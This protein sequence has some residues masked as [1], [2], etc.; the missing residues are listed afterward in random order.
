MQRAHRIRLNPTP[1][2]DRYF[3]QATGTARFTYN[4]LLGRWQA[5]KADKP[6]E[7]HGVMDLKKE[8]N[9][10]RGEQFP[11]SYDVTK[12]VIEGAARNLAT[13]FKNYF[14]SKSGKRQGPSVGFPNFKRKRDTHQSFVLNNDKF[15]VDD[16]ALN[17]PKLG[18]VD[19]TES[20]RFEGKIMGAVV[21]HD[22]DGHWYVS[23]TVDVPPEALAQ[24]AVTVKQQAVGVDVGVKT[25]ATLSDC[26]VY[27]NQ[28]LL[29][30][31]L[32]RVKRQSRTLARRVPGSHRWKAAKLALARTHRR[33]AHQRS[34][35]LHKMTTEIANEYQTVIV[36]DLNVAGMLKN[37]H[38]AQAISDASFGE[39]R[40]QLD[41]KAERVVYVGRF[42]P[43]SKLC[44]MCGHV[45]A[46]LTLKDRV[47]VCPKCGHTHERDLHAA[48]NIRAQGRGLLS[49]AAAVP[50]IALTPRA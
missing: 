25:L 23:I 24:K 2:Q 39:I 6:G 47:F 49:S 34:D 3:R 26:Q 28:V 30:S 11:W 13:A 27:K 29:R 14:D 15:S 42:F 48:Q 22:P 37:H 21:S 4:W 1:E 18:W 44:E 9:A 31:Q 20:L 5:Y 16:H 12:C 45:N 32:N 36:E 43:S 33:I 41:Y 17:V 8:F 35:I 19:M 46:E 38:L 7:K 10:I 40:R 50:D